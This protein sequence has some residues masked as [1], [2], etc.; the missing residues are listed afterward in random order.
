VGCTRFPIWFPPAGS[1]MDL[2]IVSSRE[3]HGLHHKRAYVLTGWLKI[4]AH[5][6]PTKSPYWLCRPAVDPSMTPV[7]CTQMF[8]VSTSRVLRV[9]AHRVIKGATGATPYICLHHTWVAIANSPHVLQIT[10]VAYA[11]S[12]PFLSSSQIQLSGSGEC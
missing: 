6:G 2:L 5:M 1:S 4:T 12:Y 7:G 10:Q 11:A 9:F 8:M 3:L